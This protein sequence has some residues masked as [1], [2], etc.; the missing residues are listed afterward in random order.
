VIY[1]N[2]QN[3]K[4]KNGLKAE[5]E[6]SKTIKLNKNVKIFHRLRTPFGEVDLLTID[7][8]KNIS[9]IEVKSIPESSWIFDRLSQTQ[10]KR[11][12]RCHDWVLAKTNISAGLE[13]IFVESQKIHR[14]PIQWGDL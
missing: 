5:L 8:N 10:I 2:C 7:E 12:K 6:V 3:F 4:H 13:L 14:Y 9:I 1:K 11:L